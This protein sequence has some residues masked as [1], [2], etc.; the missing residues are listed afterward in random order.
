MRTHI[1]DCAGSTMILAAALTLAAGTARAGDACQ[2][3]LVIEPSP[4]P[5]SAET[6]VLKGIDVIA[7]DD[8]WAVGDY[9]VPG[10]AR[11]LTLHFDGTD[12]EIVLSPS[13]EDPSG[14][15]RAN[16]LDIA[17][18]H[19]DLVYASGDYEG[20]FGP[21]DTFVL[22]WDG[23]DWEHIISPGQSVFGAQGGYTFQAMATIDE[24]NIWFA[25]STNET[26][27]NTRGYVVHYD[28]SSFEVV[29]TPISGMA[30]SCVRWK[31]SP[32][33]TSGSAEAFPGRVPRA[34][35]YPGGYRRGAGGAPAVIAR[36]R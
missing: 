6:V 23:G 12:W 22:R 17:A 5:P 26:P 18:V 27:G 7:P 10:A 34:T 2:A 28:G 4:D 29:P 8:I 3:E 30:R 11:S 21:S 15:I 13:P 20:P 33:T 19:P 14:D 16:L 9:V 1:F 35:P 36:S 32:P 24:E 25:G 31:R